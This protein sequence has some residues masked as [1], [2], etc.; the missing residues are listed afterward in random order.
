[1]QE[2]RTGK[3]E[4]REEVMAAVHGRKNESELN[5]GTKRVERKGKESVKIIEEM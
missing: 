4:S 3:R 5:Y 2:K 1:M